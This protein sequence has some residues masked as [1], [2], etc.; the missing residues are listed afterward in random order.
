M[1]G[2]VYMYYW[3]TLESLYICEYMVP[4]LHFNTVTKFCGRPSRS[5]MV[6]NKPLGR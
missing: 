2:R 1:D 3:V 4:T 6:R 5:L